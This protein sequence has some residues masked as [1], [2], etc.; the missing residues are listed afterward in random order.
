MAIEQ[1]ETNLAGLSSFTIIVLPLSRMLFH[2]IEMCAVQQESL[3]NLRGELVSGEGSARHLDH[4]SHLVVDLEE[5]RGFKEFG[6]RQ[7][8]SEKVRGWLR[9]ERSNF[10]VCECKYCVKEQGACLKESEGESQ[11]R[12]TPP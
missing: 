4:G 2:R 9:V 3:G 11:N 10:L 8:S 12:S 6:V 5:K 7:F 1:E